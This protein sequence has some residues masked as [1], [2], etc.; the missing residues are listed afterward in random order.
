MKGFKFIKRCLPCEPVFQ[1][2]LPTFFYTST[3]KK[4]QR[5]NRLQYSEVALADKEEIDLNEN[6]ENVEMCVYNSDEQYLS[7]I[8]DQIMTDG[9]LGQSDTI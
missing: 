1:P 4:L 3:Q 5:E 7:G 2:M 8:P 6:V 9:L